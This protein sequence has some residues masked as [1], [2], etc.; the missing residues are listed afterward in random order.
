[1]PHSL[2]KKL[3]RLLLKC[4]LTVF[5]L[6]LIYFIAAWCLSRIRIERESENEK[7]VCIFIKTNGVHTDI[8]VPA[9]NSII[10][11]TKEIRYEYTQKADSPYAWLAMGWGDKGFYLE[12][13]AWADLKF[14][15]AFKATFALSTSA[16]HAT[17]YDRMTEDA[18][19]RKIMISQKQYKR[20]VR[21]ISSSFKKDAKGHFI[22]IVTDANYGDTDAFY[23]AVGSYSL[24]RTC[25]TWANRA[26]KSCGQRC[27]YWTIFDTGIFRQYET[28]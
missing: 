21:Y 26:L 22:R 28:P 3:L 6:L 17:F 7:E 25:N 4:L 14:S 1:M 27:C 15:V 19:C 10:N 11:W 20:L 12:T 24:F 18:T 16:I 13:P 5:S 2:F 23:E 9:V 8:V